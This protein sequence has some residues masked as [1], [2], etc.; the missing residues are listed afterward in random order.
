M[1]YDKQKEK[2]STSGVCGY[3]W[4][5][6]PE[7]KEWKERKGVREGVPNQIALVMKQRGKS[8]KEVLHIGHRRKR[9]KLGCV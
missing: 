3:E 7:M 9:Q 4:K 6:N 5:Y 1:Q 2:N 8:F